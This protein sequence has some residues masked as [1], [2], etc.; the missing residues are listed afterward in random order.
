MLDR[1]YA[2]L[3]RTRYRAAGPEPYSPV[4][5]RSPQLCARG[6][7]GQHGVSA[8]D[9]EIYWRTARRECQQRRRRIATGFRAA[10]PNIIPW[11]G[12]LPDREIRPSVLDRDRRR[13]CSC[14]AC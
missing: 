1:A 7:L 3:R 8:F 2:A 10:L 9:A 6:A 4:H 14:A 13:T 12:V 5:A 11:L